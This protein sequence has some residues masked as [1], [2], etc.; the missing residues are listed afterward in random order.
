MK[1]RDIIIGYGD[2]RTNNTICPGFSI[3]T[4]I[5]LYLLVPP[6]LKVASGVLEEVRK[7]D[8]MTEENVDPLEYRIF[9]TQEECKN[10]CIKYSLSFKYID[11]ILDYASKDIL[12]GYTLTIGDDCNFLINNYL[13][14]PKDLKINEGL[15]EE[16]Q[17]EIHDLEIINTNASQSDYR[18]FKIPENTEDSDWEIIDKLLESGN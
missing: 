15:L 3:T 12:S 4:N 17:G 10:D 9:N 7:S 11:R 18:K 8:I 16:I 6:D 2:A 1:Y 13:L 14:V 5:A